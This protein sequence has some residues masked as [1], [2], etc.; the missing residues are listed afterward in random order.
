MLASCN[1]SYDCTPATVSVVHPQRRE[2]LDGNRGD[3][4]ASTSSNQRGRLGQGKQWHRLK[5]MGGNDGHGAGHGCNW[6][7]SVASAGLMRCGKSCRLRWTNY[8]RPHLKRGAISQEEEDQI[9]QLHSRFGNRYIC[10]YIRGA[11]SQE[12]EDQI[13]QLHSR[14]GNR[15]ICAYIRRSPQP[16]EHPDQER[17]KLQDSNLVTRKL[18]DHQLS[19]ISSQASASRA[20]EMGTDVDVSDIAAAIAFLPLPHGFSGSQIPGCFLA[21]GHHLPNGCCLSYA[22]PLFQA[23]VVVSSPSSSPIPLPSSLPH[24]NTALHRL[25]L[26]RPL[27]LVCPL[28]QGLPLSRTLTTSRC[29]PSTS[30]SISPLRQLLMPLLPSQL[31]SSSLVISGHFWRADTATYYCQRHFRRL[32]TPSR[33]ANL[34]VN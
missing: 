9:I 31:L 6:Q 22:T 14:F 34:T 33:L 24:R 13:I 7:C 20:K 18:I 16:L 28:S 21:L 32:P 17:F 25:G 27:P 15:Y 1:T 19:G 11:I 26:Q 30:P 29:H 23:T 12:E 8:L 3:E 5:E 2:Q 10:A 4:K